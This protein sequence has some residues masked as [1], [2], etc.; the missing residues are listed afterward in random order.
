MAGSGYTDLPGKPT[1]LWL[2]TTPSTDYA[3]LNDGSLA[4]DVAIVGGGLV[5]LTAATLLKKEGQTVAV[6]EAGR[7]AAGVTGHTT[8][9]LTSLHTLIYDHLI[10]NVGETKA[11]LYGEANQA[12]IELVAQLVQ[13]RGIDCDFVRDAAFTYTEVPSKVDSI[14]AEAKAAMRLGLPASLVTETPLPFPVQA[15]VRFDNQARFHP[16]KYLLALAEN[17]TGDGSYLFEE[18]RVVDVTEGDP[19]TIT[20]E[21]GTIMAR[22]VI[23]ASHFP[24]PDPAMYFARM[25]PHRSYV[26][27][28]RL[29]GDRTPPGM[30][31]TGETPY[32]SVRPHPLDDGTE[33]LLI[34]GE[35][36]KTGQGGDTVARYQRL[37]QWARDRFP[38]A[39][40]EYRWSTQDNKTFDQIP[41]IGKASPTSEHLYVGTGFGGWGMTGSTVAG[42]LLTDLILGRTNAWSEVYHPNR[43][44]LESVPSLIKENVDS[45]VHLVGDRLGR[46]KE[47]DVPPGEGVILETDDGK[48]AAYREPGGKLH[49]MSAVC[50][51]MGCIVGWNPAEKSW[52]CPCHGSRFTAEGEV[53]H[54]PAVRGLGQ[55]PVFRENEDRVPQSTPEGTPE[56]VPQEEKN[57]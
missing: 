27:A 5:G 31:I 4:V 30:Y 11:R 42:M 48:V 47:A 15:A 49:R 18:T 19:C 12:A 28:V 46:D 23:L 25:A 52:D 54:A 36:H 56:S 17:L 14:E 8:G 24:V 1:S 34:G 45:A 20:T 43:F 33:L 6:L 7:I 9:K 40:V 13:E 3:P 55:K 10:R 53:L 37:E 57:T 41:F 35:G 16:R 44:N 38:V 21:R 50:T 2:G 26:L 32:H 29:D 22:E 51:H 39:S